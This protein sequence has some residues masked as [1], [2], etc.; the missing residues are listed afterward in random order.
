MCARSFVKPRQHSTRSRPATG[1]RGFSLTEMVVAIGISAILVAAL[2]STLHLATRTL[3]IANSP[4]AESSALHRFTR[5]WAADLRLALDFENVRST[6]VR[7]LVPDR[8]GDGRAESIEYRWTGSPDYSITRVLDLSGDPAPAT[9]E[10]LQTNVANVD[11]VFLIEDAGLPA[12]IADVPGDERLLFSNDDT[13]DSS[14]QPILLIV[15]DALSLASE[16][17][18][19]KTLLE[20]WGHLVVPA[21]HDSVLA[22]FTYAI[23]RPK[24]IFVAVDPDAD[25]WETVMKSAS[26]GIVSQSDSFVDE[27]GFGKRGPGPTLQASHWVDDQAHSVTADVGLGTWTLF[28]TPQPVYPLKT[29]PA[30]LAPDLRILSQWPDGPGLATLEAGDETYDTNVVDAQAGITSILPLLSSPTQDFN[31]I[32]AMRTYIPTKARLKSISGHLTPLRST[33]VRFGIYR[34]DNGQIGTLIRDTDRVP[35]SKSEWKKADLDPELIVNSGWYWLAVGVGIDCQVHYQDNA[36]ST[37]VV[38]DWSGDVDTNLDTT[39]SNPQPLARD[40]SLNVEYEIIPT[41]TGR[42]VRLPWGDDTTV[43]QLNDSGQQLLRQAV[44]WA[45][46]PTPNDPAPTL[47]IRASTPANIT[48]M[49]GSAPSGATAWQL[50][51]TYVQIR[52]LVDD[53]SKTLIFRLFQAD[54]NGNPGWL[55]Q[56]TAPIPVTRFSN[57]RFQWYEVPFLSSPRQTI[58]QRLVLQ[59]TTDAGEPIAQVTGDPAHPGDVRVYAYGRYWSPGAAQ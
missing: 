23:I 16:E 33:D 6:E 50:E 7:F 43:D 4:A 46:D 55:L 3:T 32:F 45:A 24:L 2:T 11:F 42:R 20:S 40:Y 31:K 48:F 39:L 59:I 54:E 14:D 38:A 9:I 58:S 49:P 44:E 41:A 57:D 36:S 52:R 8:D 21:S 30:E 26:A 19:L 29:D 27:L 12:A 22:A 1:S 17:R 13:P 47:T 25:R 5:Q 37:A 53:A 56:E 28:E 15:D 51:R 35:V 10:T 34:D 18:D